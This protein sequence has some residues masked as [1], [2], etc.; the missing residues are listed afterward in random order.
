MKEMVIRLMVRIK[1]NR[2]TFTEVIF[3]IENKTIEE[4]EQRIN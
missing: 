1:S 4:Q 2:F 3:V